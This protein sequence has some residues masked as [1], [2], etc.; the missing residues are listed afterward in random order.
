M[1]AFVRDFWNMMSEGDTLGIIIKVW[2]FF[3]L[4]PTVLLVALA[5]WADILQEVIR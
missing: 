5:L 1:K 2:F 3:L 4:M